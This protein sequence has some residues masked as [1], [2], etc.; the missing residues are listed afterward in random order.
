ML[1]DVFDS[2]QTGS[3]QIRLVGA[4]AIL[5][6]VS[7]LGALRGLERMRMTF[8]IAGAVSLTNIVLDPILIFGW[9]PVP[10]LGIA[11]AA[12]ATTASQ[13]GGAAFALVAVGRIIGY[14]RRPNWRRATGLLV[15]GRDMVARTSALLFF[16]LLIGVAL[17]R[18]CGNSV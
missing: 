12:W 15:V 14:S 9:G 16:L 18:Q 5:I 7:S 2:G 13:A 11:G 6:V 17:V 4:P 3:L 10:A 1:F 8:W